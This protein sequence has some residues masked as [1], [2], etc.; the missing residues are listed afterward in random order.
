MPHVLNG[1]Q[2]WA[3]PRLP[4]G[5]I[6]AQV[7]RLAAIDRLRSRAPGDGCGDDALKPSKD[8]PQIREGQLTPIGALNVM[9]HDGEAVKSQA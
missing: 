7:H 5:P 6:P 4:P 3:R 9:G 2:P 1:E 8:D